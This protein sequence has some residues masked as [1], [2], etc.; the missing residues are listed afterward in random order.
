MG[1]RGLIGHSLRPPLRA[2][3]IAPLLRQLRHVSG[4]SRPELPQEHLTLH[5]VFRRLGPK[6]TAQVRAKG[7]VPAVL[8]KGRDFPDVPFCVR[9]SDIRK[10]S[11]EVRFKSML[12]KLVLRPPAE[13]DVRALS[14]NHQPRRDLREMRFVSRQGFK[15]EPVPSRLGRNS[16]TFFGDKTIEQHAFAWDVKWLPV[17]LHPDRINFKP[18]YVDSQVLLIFRSLHRR[19]SM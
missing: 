16:P 3:P 8:Y 1:L 17:F 13:E 9:M 5:G 7:F 11:E 19:S 12:F 2:L 15:F 6:N 18:Y 10:L 4:S 14:A